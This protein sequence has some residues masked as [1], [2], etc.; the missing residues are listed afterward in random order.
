MDIKNALTYATNILENSAASRPAYVLVNNFRLDAEVLLSF[1]VEKPRS[2]LFT[3]PEHCLSEK[4]ELH[5][6]ELV[7]KRTSNFPIAY[8]VRQQ[9]FWSLSFKVTPSVLI[10]RPETECLVEFILEHFSTTKE[11]LKGLDLGTGSGAIALALASEK[12]EWD[13]IACDQSEHALSI[14]KENKENLAIN[15]VELLQSN[16]FQ[17]IPNCTFDFIVSNPPYVEDNAQELIH[18][19]I[20]FEPR[21]ALCSGEDGL[22][23]I[24]IICAHAANYL[25]TNAPLIIEHGYAQADKVKEIFEHNRFNRVQCFNDYANLNRF[26]VGYT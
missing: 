21:S 3:W 9:E 16:W 2:F 12:P 23:D 18:E 4:Q 1:C 22:N 11:K 5:F 6:K 17:N 20:Q 26:T 15:N 10:P 8:L 7:A 13:I 24:K 19:S 14:A 25:K